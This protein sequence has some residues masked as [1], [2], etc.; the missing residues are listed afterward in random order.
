MKKAFPIRFVLGPIVVFTAVGWLVT[1]SMKAST[2]RVVPVEE[3]LSKPQ[4]FSGQRLRVAGFVAHTPLKTV[5]EQT[6]AGTASVTH[7]LVDDGKKTN[8]PAMLVEFRDALPDTFH[9]GGPIQ[10]DGVVEGDRIKAEH[11][12]T[13]CPSKYETGEGKKDGDDKYKNYEKPA[14]PKSVNREARADHSSTQ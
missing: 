2:L 6:A 13:K 10:V 1:S 11:V 7:F 5:T 4:Q 3:V 8:K 12:Y 14:A 9:K